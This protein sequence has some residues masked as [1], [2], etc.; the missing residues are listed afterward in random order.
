MSYAFKLAAVAIALI[1]AFVLGI[2]IFS[3][4]WYQIGLGAALVVICVP[5]LFFAWRADRKARR[6]RE[7]LEDI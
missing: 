3:E 4:I 2:V 7:G 6:A 1:V 5:L